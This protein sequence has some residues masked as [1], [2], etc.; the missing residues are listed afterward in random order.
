M[1]AWMAWSLASLSRLQGKHE[2][3]VHSTSMLVSRSVDLE[4][5]LGARR[6]VGRS[7]QMTWQAGS[8]WK[9]YDDAIVYNKDP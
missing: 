6:Q 5:G 8:F 7:K 4:L 9:L 2:Q 1:V 3:G